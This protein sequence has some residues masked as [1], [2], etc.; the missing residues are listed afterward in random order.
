MAYAKGPEQ[1]SNEQQRS[2]VISQQKEIDSKI[3]SLI[4]DRIAIGNSLKNFPALHIGNLDD[5]DGRS[6]L[7]LSASTLTEILLSQI[8]AL[9]TEKSQQKTELD[10]AN[11]KEREHQDE[12]ETLKEQIK[13][14]KDKVDK[15]ERILEQ[16]GLCNW[17]CVLRCLAST[18]NSIYNEKL[19]DRQL[20]LIVA[21]H[22]FRKKNTEDPQIYSNHEC[23]PII[24]VFLLTEL[25]CENL[26]EILKVLELVKK[27]G[28]FEFEQTS[29]EERTKA[30]KYIT[31]EDKTE[32]LWLAFVK[33]PVGH[34]VIRRLKQ[35]DSTRVWI[36]DP[37]SGEEKSKN[38]EDF[39]AYTYDYK[40]LEVYQFNKKK[41]DEIARLNI[42]ILG[43][44]SLIHKKTSSTRDNFLNRLH[45]YHLI[46]MKLKENNQLESVRNYIEKLQ[47]SDI[48]ALSD[49]EA[50]EIAQTFIKNFSFYRPI[51][52]DRR[53]CTKVGPEKTSTEDPDTFIEESSK[54][55][56]PMEIQ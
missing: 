34:C 52:M 6:A 30:W 56:I 32:I 49:R 21:C 37:Q 48:H 35:T 17:N 43:F 53:S 10:E 8:N 19:C 15:L 24:E 28:E 4:M 12:I 45:F 16:K 3:Q 25:R 13:D 29:K 1:I 11:Q 22:Y 31:K 46:Q 27:K 20:Q 23:W 40:C 42:D 36:E 41:W 47:F 54:E 55:I 38:E 50:E 7:E 44:F 18:Y 26:L 33:Q 2:H 14:Y 39:I 51:G 9:M 5:Y